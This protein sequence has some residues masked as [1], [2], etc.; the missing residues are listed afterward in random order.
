MYHKIIKVFRGNSIQLSLHMYSNINEYLHGLHIKFMPC[1]PFRAIFVFYHPLISIVLISVDTNF[2]DLIF[3]PYN[4]YNKQHKMHVRNQILEK[5]KERTRISRNWMVHGIHGGI[6]IIAITVASSL[7]HMMRMD[8]IL[9]ISQMKLFVAR[10]LLL[11]SF[12][13]LISPNL[14]RV[15]YFYSMEI[16]STCSNVQC[17]IPPHLDHFRFFLSFFLS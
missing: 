11:C 5:E 2:R 16:V 12:S 10:V 8:D 7:I 4:K 1:V 15:A 3:H 13:N 17:I 9:T 6:I 14:M